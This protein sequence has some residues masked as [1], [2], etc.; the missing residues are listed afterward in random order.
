MCVF[1]NVSGVSTLIGALALVPVLVVRLL[2]L[3]HLQQLYGGSGREG[4]WN[5]RPPD[6]GYSNGL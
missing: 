6:V 4:L 2:D 1:S 5:L 3:E